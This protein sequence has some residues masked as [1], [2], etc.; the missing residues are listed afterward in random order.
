MR[1]EHYW[2]CDECGDEQYVGPDETYMKEPRGNEV[3]DVWICKEC[4]DE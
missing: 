4:E 3:V 1:S 2:T